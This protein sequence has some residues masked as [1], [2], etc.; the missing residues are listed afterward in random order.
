MLLYHG[1]S[2]NAALKAL[3]NGLRPRRETGVSNWDHTSPSNPDLV[4]LT[5]TYACHFALNAQS[6]GVRLIGEDGKVQNRM[7]VIEIDTRRLPFTNLRADEDFLAFRQAYSSADPAM[8]VSVAVKELRSAL[9]HEWRDSLKFIGNCAYAGSIPPRVFT[10]VALFDPKSNKDMAHAM[11]DGSVNPVAYKL[12][13]HHHR[14]Y[15]RWLFGEPVTGIE[16]LGLQDYPEESLGE[17]ERPRIE[18]WEQNI[19]NK[20]EGV[21][22]IDLRK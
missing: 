13:G 12:A 5:D 15:L 18:Y 16:A 3:K 6:N 21:E 4:Y 14:T 19:L 2:E 20:R 22:I 10:R 17:F 1:T 8:T 11:M 9:S 7:A